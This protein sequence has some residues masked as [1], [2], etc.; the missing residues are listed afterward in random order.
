MEKLT[1]KG[2]VDKRFGSPEYLHGNQNARKNPVF[3]PQ[4]KVGDKVWLTIPVNGEIKKITRHGYE[5]EVADAK[6]TYAFFDDRDVIRK[7]ENV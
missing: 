5:I 1:K 2:K 7:I 6:G 4:L 3:K